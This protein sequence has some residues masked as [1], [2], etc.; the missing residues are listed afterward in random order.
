[1]SGEFMPVDAYT[2]LRRVVLN[3]PQKSGGDAVD[4]DAARAYLVSRGFAEWDASAKKLV[5]TKAG[6]EFG[7]I[8]SKAP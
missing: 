3:G 7:R 1:M 2:L 8:M 6:K 5:A 4:D